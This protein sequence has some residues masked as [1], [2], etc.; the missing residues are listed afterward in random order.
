ME[1]I[2]R[3]HPGDSFEEL[4]ALLHRAYGAL[5]AMGFNYT[6]VDQP[7]ERTRQ[8]ASDGE[9]YVVV[10]GGRIVGTATLGLVERMREPPEYGRRGMAFLTQFAIAPELQGNGLGSRL[11]RHAEERAR[12]LGACEIALDTAEGAAHLVRYYEARGYAFAGHVRFEGKTYRS[13]VLSKR[14]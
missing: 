8:R 5:G 10:D 4:T 7:V 12:E 1:E 14:L 6:A 3:L 9:C 2:R 13:V 11:L